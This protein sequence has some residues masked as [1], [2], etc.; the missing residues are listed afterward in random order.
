MATEKRKVTNLT[1]GALLGRDDIV[2]LVEALQR[3]DNPI[4][5]AVVVYLDAEQNIGY[6][7]IGSVTYLEAMG[8]L[9]WATNEAFN[10]SDDD[11]EGVSDDENTDD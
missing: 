4:S 3:E 11:D 9:T 1:V 7:A 8:M 2:D 5:K 6:G 10:R